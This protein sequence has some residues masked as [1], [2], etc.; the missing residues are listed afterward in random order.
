MSLVD[1]HVVGWLAFGNIMLA[2]SGARLLDLGLT[3]SKQDVA[4]ANEQRSQHSAEDGPLTAQG[5]TF[6]RVQYMATE[7]LNGKKEVDV[8]TDVFAYGSVVY[9][10]ATGKRAF[11]GKSQA[12]LPRRYWRPIR[13]SQRSSR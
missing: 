8:R 3:K 4:P 7:Q 6:G 9:D 10:I 1:R 13:R 5:M 2:I 12:S 11:E